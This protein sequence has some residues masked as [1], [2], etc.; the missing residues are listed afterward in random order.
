MH[1]VNVNPKLSL[2]YQQQMMTMNKYYIMMIICS[3]NPSL[4][5]TRKFH[6]V[7]LNGLLNSI[8]EGIKAAAHKQARKHMNA[9]TAEERSGGATLEFSA[10]TTEA[11]WEDEW[12]VVVVV[13]S[14][15]VSLGVS[16]WV[17]LGVSLWALASLQL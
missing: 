11:V 6:D 5:T 8:I 2:P 12:V 17:S 16:L 3:H 9:Q 1:F 13:R 4:L 7:L 10:P 15:W 14:L